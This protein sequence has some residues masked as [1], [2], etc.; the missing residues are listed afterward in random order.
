[1]ADRYLL[2]SSSVDGYLLEDGTGVYLLEGGAAGPINAAISN[3]ENPVRRKAQAGQLTLGANLLTTTLAVAVAY[4]ARDPLFI[5]R[6]PPGIVQ[7]PQ[8]SAN[9]NLTTLAPAPVQAPFK[10]FQ[11]DS[12]RA[13]V[14][15]QVQIPVNQL[16]LSTVN[17]P[18]GTA[19]FIERLSKGWKQDQFSFNNLPLN[20]V[21]A[22]NLPFN[23]ADWQN[24]VG[25]KKVQQPWFPGRLESDPIPEVVIPFNQLD[26]VTPTNTKRLQDTSVYNRLPLVDVTPPATL[27][28]N[29]FDWPTPGRNRN[30]LV[31]HFSDTASYIVSGDPIIPVDW[32]VV[33]K[34]KR[35]Y[36]PDSF[37]NLQSTT[38]TP[39]IVP[40]PFIPA[41]FNSPWKVKGTQ[42]VD[43]EINY[44]PLQ[45]TAVQSPFNQF[46]WPNPQRREVKLASYTLDTGSLTTEVP[47]VPLV[48]NNPVVKKVKQQPDTQSG[49]LQLLTYVPPV[50]PTLN[51]DWP[52]PVIARRVK[53]PD[54]PQGDLQLLTYI[55]PAPP[56]ASTVQINL[57]LSLSRL[58][59]RVWG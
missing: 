17:L 49:L 28:F 22:S 59:G 46:D 55:P 19:V 32:P 26:W 16:V 48:F 6:P 50:L 23:Q 13:R 35:N 24:P 18:P 29:Q 42:Q 1:M 56:G 53:Q 38:L 44:L 30:W 58:G 10:P 43:V 33:R 21:V 3:L 5:K 34:V 9:L 52:N 47:V 54:M 15:P 31:S 39:P 45:Q 4:I 12:V 14:Q 57:G 36:Q 51:Y 25:G 8:V 37:P 11:V 27:P 20:S 7:P 41:L 40:A 2:E